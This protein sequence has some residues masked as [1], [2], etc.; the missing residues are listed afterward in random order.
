MGAD[1]A[2]AAAASA[3]N[4]T[5]GAAV[6]GTQA[7]WGIRGPRPV[8]SGTEEVPGYENFRAKPGKSWAT[9]EGYPDHTIL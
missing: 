8:L 1:R 3:T 7:S 6:I 9:Q 2:L 5:W 4:Q